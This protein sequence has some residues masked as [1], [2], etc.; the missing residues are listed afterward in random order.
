MK[1]MIELGPLDR[2]HAFQLFAIFGGD[3][4]K[5][6]AA[7]EVHPSAVLKAA[8]E[9]GWLEK[10]KPILDLRASARPGDWERSINR[11]KNYIQAFRFQVFLE[12]VMGKL[13]ALNDADLSEHIFALKIGKGE[14]AAVTRTIATRGL[15]DLASAL[16]KAHS[17]TYQALND[18]ATERT[19]RKERDGQDEASGD[20]FVKISD[21]MAKVKSSTSPRAQLL[22]AQLAEAERIAKESKQ[23]SPLDNDNH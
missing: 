13:I 5:V 19:K 15:A 20:L 7:L 9:E 8:E 11:A 4:I 3:I 22:D 16:E 1:D 6:A 12:R 21:A 2:G 18:T 23:T 10:L 17:M 14:D